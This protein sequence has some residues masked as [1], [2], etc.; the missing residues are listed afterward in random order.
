MWRQ[1][2]L[3]PQAAKGHRGP[4]PD[5]T[6]CG[7]TGEAGAAPGP[8]PERRGCWKAIDSSWQR[9]RGKYFH[10]VT[11]H[12]R[13]GSL[14]VCN[15]PGRRQRAG[16]PPPP[17][18][19]PPSPAGKC[20]ARAPLRQTAHGTHTRLCHRHRMPATTGTSLT[21]PDLSAHRKEDLSNISK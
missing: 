2:K 11:P 20:P 5:T 19:P 12:K 7:G 16:T 1:R 15:L 13:T 14:R 10:H 6:R 21:E 9:Q 18:L 17:P 8:P 3:P 4:A